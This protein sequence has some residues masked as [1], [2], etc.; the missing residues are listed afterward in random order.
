MIRYSPISCGTGP[1][2]RSSEA[3]AAIIGAALKQVFRDPSGKSIAFA[4]CGAGGLL[5]EISA[6]FGRV[7]GYD[8]TLPVLGAA[9]HLLDGKNLDLALPRA[10]K[11]T[12]H[13][14]LRK[15]DPSSST[16]H[17]ELQAMDVLIR[18]LPMSS[19]IAPSPHL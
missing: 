5:A 7:L 18:R 2:H 19:S 13:I 10:I 11:E 4:G 17:I 6:E 1:T 12:G 3:A 14:H 8:L 15:R 9:R 16:S